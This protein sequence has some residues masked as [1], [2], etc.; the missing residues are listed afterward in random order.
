[1]SKKLTTRLVPLILVIALVLTFGLVLAYAAP[2]ADT[3]YAWYND[4]NPVPIFEGGREAVEISFDWDG[5]LSAFTYLEDLT[6]D[7]SVAYK[8]YATI[9]SGY[10]GEITAILFKAEYDSEEGKW[11][12]G[13]RIL[14][15]RDGYEIGSGEVDYWLDDDIGY[16][17][18]PNSDYI[19]SLYWTANGA[20]EDGYADYV[21]RFGKM[22]VT[23]TFGYGTTYTFEGD[24]YSWVDEDWAGGAFDWL[25]PVNGYTDVYAQWYY[26]DGDDKVYLSKETNVGTYYDLK[27]ELAGDDVGCYNLDVDYGTDEY[28]TPLDSVPSV[29]INKAQAYV[30]EW[31]W[32]TNPD[33]LYMLTDGDS[34]PYT[35]AAPAFYAKTNVGVDAAITWSAG[36]FLD[37]DAETGYY[38]ITNEDTSYLYNGEYPVDVNSD[39]PSHWYFAIATLGDTTNFDGITTLSP[40]TFLGFKISKRPIEITWDVEN[41]ET[42]QSLGYN[43]YA[44]HPGY[45]MEVLGYLADETLEPVL[46]P[47]SDDADYDDGNITTTDYWTYTL[48]LS[49]ADQANYTIQDSYNGVTGTEVSHRYKIVKGTVGVRITQ[50]PDY[51]F[52]YRQNPVTDTLWDAYEEAF[53]VEITHTGSSTEFVVDRTS[54]RF[55]DPV[56][57]T[58]SNDLSFI[59]KKENHPGTYEVMVNTTYVPYMPAM[60]AYDSLTQYYTFDGNDYNAVMFEGDTEKDMSEQELT[61]YVAFEDEYYYNANDVVFEFELEKAPV[62][63]RTS[64]SFTYEEDE[65]WTPDAASYE[66][67]LYEYDADNEDKADFLWDHIYTDWYV[68]IADDYTWWDTDPNEFYYLLGDV[69]HQKTDMVN[70]DNL[71][72]FYYK[73]TP[74]TGNSYNYED[75]GTYDL[76]AT[77]FDGDFCTWADDYQLLI[78]DGETVLD[79]DAVFVINP[80]PVTVTITEPANWFYSGTMKSVTA[81]YVDTK[82]ETVNLSS[83]TYSYVVNPEEV[84][85]LIHVSRA[86]NV[87]FDILDPNYIA[88]ANYDYTLI[89]GG[90]SVKTM[91]FTIDKKWITLN[92]YPNSNV[93]YGDDTSTYLFRPNVP[94]EQF[95]AG[96]G[97]MEPIAEKY[98]WRTTPFT[99]PIDTDDGEWTDAAFDQYSDVGTY[100]LYWVAEYRDYSTVKND[101][102]ITIGQK[103]LTVTADNKATTY[104]SAAPAFTATIVGLVNGDTLSGTNTITSAYNIEDANNRAATT[105]AITCSAETFVNTNYDI[106]FNSGTLTVNAKAITVTIDN[107]SSDYGDADWA[108][109]TYA[110]L[111]GAN[112]LEYGDAAPFELNVYEVYYDEYDTAWHG[113]VLAA[114]AENPVNKKYFIVGTLT[115]DTN[116]AVTF[117][118]DYASAGT[119]SVGVFENNKVGKYTI[120]KVAPTYTAP[121]INAP[122]SAYNGSAQALWTAGTVTGGSFEYYMSDTDSWTAA[123]PTRTDWRDGGYTTQWRI[124]PDDNHTAVVQNG[125]TNINIPKRTIQYHPV[126]D[127]KSTNTVK[128]TGANYTLTIVVDNACTPGE[129]TISVTSHATENAKAGYTSTIE[130]AG[131]KA[132]NYQFDNETAASTQA[133]AISDAP[134]EGVSISQKLHNEPGDNAYVL[135]Y[136]GTAQEAEISKAATTE[137][138]TPYTFLYRVSLSEGDWSE[139]LPT[140]TTA[141]THYVYYKVTATNHDDY[142]GTED[143]KFAIVINPK[144]LTPTFTTTFTYGDLPSGESYRPV[145]TGWDTTWGFVEGDENKV[146]I[147]WSLGTTNFVGTWNSVEFGLTAGASGDASG[148]YYCGSYY[149]TMT[150]NPKELTLSWKIWDGE[151]ASAVS[152]VT[153]AKKEYSV[154]VYAETGVGGETV[155]TLSP[156]GNTSATDWRQAAYVASVGYQNTSYSVS[157]DGASHA[158]YVISY[159][160]ANRT[161]EWTIEKKEIGL[162]WAYTGATY[163]E[164]AAIYE[165]IYDGN[166]HM[167]T[168]TATGVEDGDTVTVSVSGAQTR[169]GNS[170]T[171]TATANAVND[172]NYKLPEANTTTFRIIAKSLSVNW[173]FGASD[174]DNENVIDATHVYYD[175]KAHEFV[176]TPVGVE[177]ADSVTLTYTAATSYTDA[178]AHGVAVNDGYFNDGDYV[179]WQG[180]PTRTKTFYI[181]PRP[182]GVTWYIDNGEATTGAEVAYDGNAHEVTV[183]YTNLVNAGDLNAYNDIATEDEL[184][185]RNYQEGGFT[186]SIAAFESGNYTL[187]SDSIFNWSITKKTIAVTFDWETANIEPVTYGASAAWNALGERMVSNDYYFTAEDVDLGAGDTFTGDNALLDVWL[188][189]L[190]GGDRITPNDELAVGTYVLKATSAGNTNYTI[191]AITIDGEHNKLVVVPAKIT[192]TL[193]QKGTLAYNGA[194]QEAEVDNTLA[195]LNEQGITV[196]YSYTNEEAG[197]TLTKVPTFANVIGETDGKN[198]VF[199]KVTAPNHED[200]YLSFEVTITK[201]ALAATVSVDDTTYGTAI[202]A[203]AVGKGITVTGWQGDSDSDKLITADALQVLYFAKDGNKSFEELLDDAFKAYDFEEEGE[204]DAFLAAYSQV[205]VN[206]GAYY[207]WVSIDDLDN[208]RG[209]VTLGEFT[210]NKALMTNFKVAQKGTLTYNGKAQVATVDPSATSV[211]DQLVTFTYRAK[212]GDAFGAMPPFTEAGKYTV[213]YRASAAN[214]NDAFGSFDVTIGSKAL[215][216]TLTVNDTVYGTAFKVP[217]LNDGF[218]VT[219]FVDGESDALITAEKVTIKFAPIAANATEDDINAL[220]E[221]KDAWSLDV[222]TEAG[223]YLMRFGIFKIENYSNYYD[224]K[225]FTI[226]KKALTVTAASF[227]VTYGDAVPTYT[228]SYAG[229][230][231]GE[232]KAALGGELKFACAYTAT[233]AVDSYPIVASGYESANYDIKYVDGAVTVGNATLTGVSAAQ[234][235]TLTYN[236]AAQ[237]AAV[238]TAATAVNAQ[239]VAFTYSATEDGTYAAT[240]PAFT[241]AGSHIVY[242]KATAANHN[243]ATGSFKVAIEKADPGIDISAIPTELNYTGNVVKFEGATSFATADPA[244]GVLVYTNN[245]QTKVG[246]YTIKVSFEA[247]ANFVASEKTLTVKLTEAAVQTTKDES[248]GESKAETY[249][250]ITEEEA[251]SEE[252]VSITESIKSIYQAAKDANIPVV[253]LELKI[254]DDATVTFDKAALALL[255][256]ATEDVKIVYVET[257]KEDVD[258]SNKALKNAE[259]VIDVSL[260]GATLSDGKAT[261]TA[262]FEDKAPGGKK[263]VVYYVD[264]NGKKTNMNATFENGIVTFETPHFSTYVVEYVLTGGSIAGI[265]IGC[266]VGVAAIAVAVFFLLKKKKGDDKKA[267]DAAADKTEEVAADEAEATTE[268]A[269]ESTEATAEEAA[270][271]EEVTEA[272]AEEAAP[273]APAEEAAP[274]EAA[275]KAKKGGKKGKK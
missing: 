32:T 263:A 180:E 174:A 177:G 76:R 53:N 88:E 100:Y 101:K 108:D 54:W 252:G 241:V 182:V 83:S 49:V 102:T 28:M 231:Y 10:S 67:Y 194:A 193:T 206:A 69:F 152:S 15:M 239:A 65:Y 85:D 150:V 114:D 59:A 234:S 52:Y 191:T 181:N 141:G 31:R 129:V 172:P 217:A 185:Q 95:I 96:E 147:D 73:A 221:D 120:N 240:V 8:T 171:R 168:A 109:L 117:A 199:Y 50:R 260:K 18:E 268:E 6:F 173:A 154:R 257:K 218:T 251:K 97:D 125:N 226:A 220:L 269:A 161:F 167:P 99:Y 230:E 22:Q 195:T 158:N 273:E 13:E 166:S 110:E 245:E 146:A 126:I 188:E 242:Y 264:E 87:T 63:V 236:K 82:G 79:K 203:P 112:A 122:L 200:L 178:G 121:T 136:N 80:C 250:D 190:E 34:I 70:G 244:E 16:D 107:V 72:G 131:D 274:A 98:Y 41:P 86:F 12:A 47:R 205:P 151:T 21:I 90:R 243:V 275:P 183:A 159:S 246:T 133:W 74:F 237:A 23:P 138:S 145:P 124:V 20:I 123:I 219:G 130:L 106:T 196:R 57:A 46:T 118:A 5:A 91:N 192:G 139:D 144:R 267:Y 227:D 48:A 214:H 212:A 207:V 258:V 235:G 247:T 176:A 253:A 26:M 4:D 249:K 165:Y 51:H 211:N 148:N 89:D 157:A 201:A 216:V 119:D 92:T 127:G 81:S 259:L 77:I 162:S 248:T 30:T 36:E 186:Y 37:M 25:S 116:Y 198:V 33:P 103:A 14:G 261:I 71:A 156:E 155:T 175:G 170:T 223:S 113:Q 61:Y 55:Y 270:P 135:T 45:T 3:A 210:I 56:S 19:V 153:Y 202:T 160:N 38:S 265:V 58:W 189:P 164:Q 256:D 128:W 134:I 42:V 44:Q 238:T 104:G 149:T 111:T 66:F 266:V 169:S 115:G 105:Y 143:Y 43:G 11:A 272:P 255:G 7:S 35:G 163:N 232:T 60:G 233:S 93:T 140:F 224:F 39:D 142:G 225:T 84:V 17:F 27:V 209:T 254:G 68:Y 213:E 228:V 94:S 78:N 187:V 197:Y 132:Y 1:M 208:Y 204:L 271:A 62:Y 179:L 64:D 184:S 40:S 215:T 137:N 24:Y 222:P 2:A 262:A 229:F 9:V 75:A 29:T